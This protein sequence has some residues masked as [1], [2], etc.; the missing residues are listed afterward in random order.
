[1]IRPLCNVACLGLLLLAASNDPATA[2]DA[3]G[4]QLLQFDTLDGWQHSAEP[5]RGWTI[6]D[7]RLTGSE[8]ATPLLGGWTLGDFELRFDWSVSKSGKLLVTLPKMPSGDGMTTSWGRR[9]R[10]ETAG[11]NC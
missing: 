9:G 2:A 4:V 10:R 11:S 3:T 6:K 1:M 8:G 5:V 7:G